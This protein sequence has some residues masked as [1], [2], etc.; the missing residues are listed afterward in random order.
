MISGLQHLS[1]CERQWALIH[2]EQVWDENRFTQEGQ[3]LHERVDQEGAESRGDVKLVRSLRLRSFRLGLIG[4]A[5]M[6]EFHRLSENSATTSDGKALGIS[7]PRK[8]GLW[9][10]FPVEY[11]RG[12][13]K[14]EPCDK[15][16]LC[17]QAL[18]LE[19]MLNVSIS[20]GALYYGQ[21]K[22]RQEVSF[23]LELRQT[24]ES[25]A[26]RMQELFQRRAKPQGRFDGKCKNCSLQETCLPKTIGKKPSVAGYLMRICQGGPVEQP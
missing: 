7:L 21:P 5:D 2:L 18:C 24:T 19:E 3:N 1:F 22:Q 25:L 17:A 12:K 13:P 11:K 9:R 14:L 10:P 16:Q 23:T 4:Q 26:I 8:K 6:V 15:I 20:A